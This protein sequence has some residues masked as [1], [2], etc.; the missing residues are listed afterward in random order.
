[1]KEKDL[2][3]IAKIEKAIKEKYGED[4]I[5]NPKR[6]WD[7]E[8]EK[9]YLEDLK[10]F[11]ERPRRS[12]KTEEVEGIIIKERK[13]IQEVDRE[14][15][16]CNSYSFSGQD[17]L[18]MTKFECCFKCYIQYVEGREERWKSGWSPNN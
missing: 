1:M 14:C 12:K 3:E 16:V 2:N 8:K 7:E 17:D 10:A 6:H 15:P 9:K 11:H 5:Q 13:S 4:A 18:Y